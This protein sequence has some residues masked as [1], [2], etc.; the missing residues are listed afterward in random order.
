MEDHSCPA[1]GE[2]F[3]SEKEKEEHAKEAHSRDKHDQE[4]DHE[5][6]NHVHGKILME[7]FVNLSCD[8][9]LT[10]IGEGS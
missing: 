1:C 2:K 8:S 4:H 3:E 6:H 5:G 10:K 9:S 7:I